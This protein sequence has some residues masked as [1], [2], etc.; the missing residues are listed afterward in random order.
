LLSVTMGDQ[1][2][3]IFVYISLCTFVSILVCLRSRNEVSG[4]ESITL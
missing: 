1:K 2:K 3:S 4:A